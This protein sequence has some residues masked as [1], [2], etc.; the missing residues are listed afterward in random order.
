MH[1]SVLHFFLQSV[2]ARAKEKISLPQ[3]VVAPAGPQCW[4]GQNKG[5]GHSSANLLDISWQSQR[6]VYLMGWV[7]QGGLICECFIGCNFYLQLL[8]QHEVIAKINSFPGTE[9][10]G[11]S[12][13]MGLMVVC[14]R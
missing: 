5:R 11:K 14:V 9:S 12:H 1:P 13:V 4:A 7:G 3:F 8:V 2:L 6:Q 10:N